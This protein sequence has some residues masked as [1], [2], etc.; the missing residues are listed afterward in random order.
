VI[1]DELESISTN[2]PVSRTAKQNQA[3]GSLE[4]PQWL[5]M[6]DKALSILVE[7]RWDVIDHRVE[8]HTVIPSRA[9]KVRVGQKFG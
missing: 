5:R 1:I 7:I 8:D 4:R 3:A 2:T 6:I 9:R